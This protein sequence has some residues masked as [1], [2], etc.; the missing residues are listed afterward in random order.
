MVKKHFPLFSKVVKP[1]VSLL[2]LILILRLFINCEG[3]NLVFGIFY[4]CAKAICN[5]IFFKISFYLK[6]A[7]KNSQRVISCF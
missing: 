7:C 2:T 5:V 3:K 4:E 6:M 1:C